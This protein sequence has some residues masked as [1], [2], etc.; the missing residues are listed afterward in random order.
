M[1]EFSRSMIAAALALAATTVLFVPLRAYAQEPGGDDLS[2][3]EADLFGSA[4][5]AGLD[6]GLDA[7][8]DAGAALGASSDV[9][10]TE[11]LVGG[12]VV[13][14]AGASFTSELD[15]LAALSTVSGKLFAKVNVPDY[16]ALYIAYNARHSLY[17]SYSGSDTA[18]DVTV[19]SDPYEPSYSLAE[20]HYSFDLAKVLFVRLGN[21]LIAWG[22]SRI[23]SPVD[24]INLEKADAFATLD[25]RV[26]KPGLRLHLPLPGANAFMFADFANLISESSTSRTGLRSGDPLESVNLGGRLDFT[27]GPFEF[28][29]TGYGGMNAQARFGAD[30][31]GRLLGTTVY[32]EFAFKPEYDDYGYSAQASLG[33][34]RSLGELKLW[35]LSGEGFYNSAGQ[36]L[37]G[38]SAGNLAIAV[39]SA[40]LTSDET[41]ALYQGEFYAYAA[42][43]A[44]ELFSPSL[45]T[46]L[47]AIVN[48][49]EQSYRLTLSE[50]FSFPRAVPFTLSVT[51]AG[52]GADKEFTRYT[53]DQ[54]FSVS[55][56]TRVEF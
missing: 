37:S 45:S 33:F 40:T 2:A 42:L 10:R 26:G 27:A 36:D 46:S 16:G 5:D 23:W 21:Q 19:A 29:L 28:G 50:S 6:S 14:S 12:T 54:A 55:A 25:A 1:K 49:T 22:P 53:G 17:Q 41:R 38:Y 18:S 56:S 8:F 48:L 52:G 32:G 47:S 39:N 7:A 31:S 34:S 15:E 20:L 4:Q 11:Y 13:A 35:T 51:Y 3:F 44:A 43:A 9:V 30:A 24:F